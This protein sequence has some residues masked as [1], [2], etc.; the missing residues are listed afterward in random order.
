MPSLNYWSA[1]VLP[2]GGDAALPQSNGSPHLAHHLMWYLRQVFPDAAKQT[3]S[4]RHYGI[5]DWSR[6]ATG[7]HQWRPGARSADVTAAL[8]AGTAGVHVCGEAFSANQGFIEGGLLSVDMALRCIADE[9]AAA[10]A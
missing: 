3:F 8:V 9:D 10:A 5:L 4:I 2:D 7:V 6:A 1:F